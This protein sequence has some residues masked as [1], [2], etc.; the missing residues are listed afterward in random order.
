M[1]TDFSAIA[2]SA[3]RLSATEREKLANK[4]L[5]SVHNRELTEIDL[6][7]LE[8]AEARFEKLRSG[9]DPGLG[10]DTFFATIEKK[11]G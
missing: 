10:E 9:E 5:E 7:W 4:L 6:A 3:S 11:L 1:D 8:V 2:E